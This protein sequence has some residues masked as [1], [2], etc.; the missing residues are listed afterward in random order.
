MRLGVGKIGVQVEMVGAGASA[1]FSR[2]P[3]SGHAFG[4]VVIGA[5]LAKWTWILF[6][7][8]T[9][10]VLPPK[11]EIVAEASAALFGVAASGA[12]ATTVGAVVSNVRLLGV[13]S[14]K[15]GFAVFK[16]DEKSQHGVALGE[17]V[18][19]GNK[20]V[21]V[22]DDHVLIEHNGARQRVNLENKFADSK[23]LVVEPSALSSTP[24]AERAV[25]EWNKARQEMQKKREQSDA[26]Q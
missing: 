26:H 23:G 20:L 19:P 14:G 7:P 16:L 22:A 4:A 2:L 17:E 21:E 18:S 24:N 11:P 9:L 12:A 5:L 3:F 10:E 6:A 25:A 15:Q 1:V 8:H 13:F